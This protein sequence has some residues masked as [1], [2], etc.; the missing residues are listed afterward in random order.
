VLK[1]RSG[2]PPPA[3]RSLRPEVPELLEQI[4]HR[5]LN[6]RPA[7]R[8]PSARELAEVLRHFSP[9]AGQPAPAA[10]VSLFSLATGELIPLVKETTIIGR[11]VKCDFVLNTLDVSRRHCRIICTPGQVLVEDLGS[12]RGTLVNGSRVTRTQLR[13]GDRLEI[14]GQVFQVFLHQTT[15]SLFPKRPV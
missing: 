12:L 2:E 7:D 10:P 15:G 13:A 6:K 11:A 1:V 9:E 3:V 4:C 14:A 8:Y 5:C